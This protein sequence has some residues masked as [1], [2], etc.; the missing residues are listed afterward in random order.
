MDTE[1]AKKAM[2]EMLFIQLI[3]MFQGAAMQQMGKLP[4]PVTQ[5]IERDLEQ[6]KMSIDMLDMLKEKTSG[7]LSGAE[8]DFLDK[9][10]FELQMNYVDESKKPADSA[11]DTAS[12]APENDQGEETGN[13]QESGGTG[14]VDEDDGGTTE[15][16]DR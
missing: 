4:N 6:A 3:A 15:T 13:G 7:N 2:Q 14:P 10:V 12:E 16:D 1:D 8:K 5:K 9:I 11:G